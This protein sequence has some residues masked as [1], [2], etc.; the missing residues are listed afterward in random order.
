MATSCDPVELLSEYEQE[1]NEKMTKDS[2]FRLFSIR[3]R[4]AN[5]SERPE[6]FTFDQLTRVCQLDT[7]LQLLLQSEGTVDLD[8]VN[9]LLHPPKHHW[10]WH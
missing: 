2:F 6:N 9:D 8:P 10:W 5:C 4:L 7:R 3:D 1:L